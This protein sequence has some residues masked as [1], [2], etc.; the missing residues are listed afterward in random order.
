MKLQIPAQILRRLD[1]DLARGG[2]REI[3]GLLMGEHIES[4][5]FRLADYSL[6]TSAGSEQHFVRDPAQ[7]QAQ[8]EAFFRRTGQDYGR[9]NYLGEWH[10]HPLFEALPSATDLEA[11]QSI[12]EDEAVGAN[13]LILLVVR[14]RSRRR[15]DISATVFL[16]R[17]A[18]RQVEVEPETA[19]GGTALCRW[20]SVLCHDVKVRTPRL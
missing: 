17:A 8:L 9:F 15:L 3:G 5:T 1:G 14:R 13:F 4:E 16:P 7:N 12:V 10:S 2:R 19:W 11:M 18:P 6:Q 20:L